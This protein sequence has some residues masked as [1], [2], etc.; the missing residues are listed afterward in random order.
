MPVTVTL[1]GSQWQVVV[2]ETE[3][4]NWLD[5]MGFHGNELTQIVMESI[6]D[7]TSNF[8]LTQMVDEAVFQGVP[9]MLVTQLVVEWIVPSFGSVKPNV[10][11][12]T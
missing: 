3:S 1:V 2:T 10:C 8:A 11:I 7:G 6:I 5:V 9:N 4:A 12:S